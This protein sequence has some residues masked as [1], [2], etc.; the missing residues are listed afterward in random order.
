[1]FFK[2]SEKASTKQVQTA[3]VTQYRRLTIPYQLGLR[4][5]FLAKEILANAV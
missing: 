3:L 1:M 4:R 5:S 2:R